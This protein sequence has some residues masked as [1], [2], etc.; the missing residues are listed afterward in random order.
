V[1]EEDGTFTLTFGKI[2]RKFKLAA[3]NNLLLV[4]SSHPSESK[5][6]FFANL[7]TVE[8]LE[9]DKPKAKAAEVLAT[10]IRETL[11]LYDL[12]RTALL[13]G[14]QDEDTKLLNSLDKMKDAFRS[15]VEAL[16]EMSAGVATSLR[17]AGEADAADNSEAMGNAAVE[18]FERMARW[19]SFMKQNVQPTQLIST[20]TPLWTDT[21]FKLLF[22]DEYRLAVGAAYKEATGAGSTSSSS[23]S[24]AAAAA[25]ATGSE[26]GV[27]EENEKRIK[28]AIKKG[29]EEMLKK[30][31]GEIDKAKAE[32]AM[33]NPWTDPHFKEAFKTTEEQALEAMKAKI[34]D[35][36]FVEELVNTIY[37]GLMSSEWT[38]GLVLKADKAEIAVEKACKA[39]LKDLGAAMKAMLGLHK[40]S[41]EVARKVA[42]DPQVK[43]QGLLPGESDIVQSSFDAVASAA[44][45]KYVDKVKLLEAGKEDGKVKFEVK[46][47]IKPRLAL[48]FIGAVGLNSKLTVPSHEIKLDLSIKDPFDAKK[49]A[50]EVKIEWKNTDA[51]TSGLEFGAKAMATVEGVFDSPKLK[52]VKV[53][54]FAKYDRGGVKTGFFTT[55]EVAGEEKD[56]K[57]EFKP[58]VIS[59]NF[60]FTAKVTDTVKIDAKADGKYVVGKSL[61]ASYTA[62]GLYRL[63]HTV[64][65]GFGLWGKHKIALDDPSKTD[66]NLLI[67][68]TFMMEFGPRAD[69]W[70]LSGR[71]GV[72][73]LQGP[74]QASQIGG[75]LLFQLEKHF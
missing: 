3:F 16:K 7:V 25:A 65:L 54:V 28:E 68:P 59:S 22:S 70:I 71:G 74:Q 63:L 43:K 44:L 36:K 14:V 34:K 2:K 60:Y 10:T 56:G 8:G 21:D 39:F 46:P 69:P 18:T 47:D 11:N 6:T 33:N 40:K 23:S 38:K 31:E 51:K 37:G 67:G 29:V 62:L 4:H 48:D 75:L 52:E 42:S 19:A 32:M 24:A 61:E 72:Q 35:P 17:A 73:I 41:A 53:S 20:T 45:S 13:S 64:Q 49:A 5:P 55:V 58:A 1:K 26:T 15:S 30:F 66:T 27:S 57:W 12:F 50:A 9:A